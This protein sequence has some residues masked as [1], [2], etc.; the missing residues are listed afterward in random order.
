MV[1][2]PVTLYSLLSRTNLLQHAWETQQSADAVCAPNSNAVIEVSFR[3]TEASKAMDVTAKDLQSGK[4]IDLGTIA[5]GEKVTSQID[6]GKPSIQGGAVQFTLKWTDKSPGANISS[7]T[8][9]AVEDCSSPTPPL[10][11]QDQPRNLGYCVWD[12]KNGA[13][14]YEVVVKEVESGDIVKSEV[15]QHPASRT[16]FLIDPDKTYQCSVSASNVCGAG[17]IAKSPEKSC[18]APTVTPTPTPTVPICPVGKLKNAICVWNPLQ[19]AIEYKIIVREVPSGKIIKEE[20]VKHP[21]NELL[22]PQEP[23]KK[24]QCSVTPVNLC[25][26][27]KTVKSPEKTCS[28]PTPTPSKTP[29]PSPTPKISPTP[30]P[31]LTPTPKPTSTPTPTNTPTPSP[32]PKPTSTPT[33]TNTPTPVPTNTPA[34]TA[35]PQPTLP[36]L[37]ITQPPLP[38]RTVIVQ[39]PPPQ[40]I[41]VQQQQPP[42]QQVIV[43]QPGLKPGVVVQPTVA[44][45]GDNNSTVLISVGAFALTVIGALLFFVL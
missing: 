12:T 16:G 17:T 2:I 33:P 7:A 20:T 34:P 14:S 45:T 37:I 6:T 3:N 28:V 19:G 8:Y 36:P 9:N 21:N 38:P 24:Y 39:Q 22:F 25:R 30:T 40:Q 15:L 1:S 26:E 4:S 23:G 27:G 31:T 10:C 43:Q 18:P 32:T 13:S 41:I 44:P 35:T 5:H 29:T 42:G 11:P